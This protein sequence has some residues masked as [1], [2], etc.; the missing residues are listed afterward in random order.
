MVD[1]AEAGKFLA[2]SGMVVLGER[3]PG[4][5]GDPGLVSVATLPRSST[6]HTTKLDY[7]AMT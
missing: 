5:S 6:R 1:S 2:N 7:G 3:V 4:Q